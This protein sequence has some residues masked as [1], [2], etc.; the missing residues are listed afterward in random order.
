MHRRKL[1]LPLSPGTFSM[2][3]AI[4]YLLAF[5]A[6]VN[7]LSE[8][9]RKSEFSDSLFDRLI[10]DVDFESRL[11]SLAV[12]CRGFKRSP[13]TPSMPVFK[14][15]RE[16]RSFRNEVL[17]G[18]FSHDDHVVRVVTED[19]Y[20]FYWWP[21]AD[22]SELATPDSS[23]LALPLTRV[24]FTKRHA[25]KVRQTV[26]AA[27]DAVIDAMQADYKAWATRWRR[28]QAIPAVLGSDGWRPSLSHK[29]GS[30]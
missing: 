22:E 29:G 11:L 1:Q 17:H 26:E 6:Y 10:V 18:S 24:L 19:H 5:E 28:E 30:V 20:M 15:I 4:K 7:V 14:S 2:A 27:I 9:L 25:E 3:A 8:L 12:F 16:L 21:A 23:S 13:F